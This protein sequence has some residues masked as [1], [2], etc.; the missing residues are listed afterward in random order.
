MVKKVVRRKKKTAQTA[1]EVAAQTSTQPASQITGQAAAGAGQIRRRERPSA[2]GALASNDRSSG[3]MPG[4]YTFKPDAGKPYRAFRL[5]F[6]ETS[7]VIRPWPNYD[8]EIYGN[9]NGRLDFGPFRTQPGKMGLI[10]ADWVRAIPAAKYFGEG[11][12]RTTCLLYNP[13]L[14]AAEYDRRTNPYIAIILAIK[15]AIKGGAP[16]YKAWKEM[17]LDRRGDQAAIIPSDSRL[18]FVQGAVCKDSK[19]IYLPG[20]TEKRLPYGMLPQD[21]TPVIQL[22]ASAV[23]GVIELAS[24]VNETWRGDPNDWENSMLYGDMVSPA[25][26]RFLTF[27]NPENETVGPLDDLSG[28]AFEAEAELKRVQQSQT[29][30][31]SSSGAKMEAQ[32]F[33]A[34]VD[35]CLVIGSQVFKNTLPKFE[36]EAADIIRQKII[37]WEDLLHIPTHDE[38][39][40]Y[41]ARACSP[42]GFM[43]QY[44]WDGLGYF[45]EEVRKICAASVQV[46]MDV[47]SSVVGSAQQPSH[48]SMSAAP[49]GLAGFDDTMLV[50]AGAAAGGAAV[51]DAEDEYE[52]VEVEVDDEEVE[53]VEEGVE[54]EVEVVAGEEGADDDEYEEVEV[55]EEGNEIVDG[56]EYEEV[57]VEE[58]EEEGDEVEEVEEVEATAPAPETVAPTPAPTPAPAKQATPPAS[59]PSSPADIARTAVENAKKR[60]AA[61]VAAADKAAGTPPAEPMQ[62]KAA[63]NGEAKKTVKKK[64]VKRKRPS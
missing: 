31:G 45:D 18:G 58:G 13:S 56:D 24:K 49:A 23:D 20:G 5:H 7:T 32:G 64:L 16:K 36:G 61:R 63:T 14:S 21:A 59:K 8:Y 40:L 55:D 39:R 22:N 48:T 35:N 50:G 37:W 34:R 30:G 9:E 6:R 57:E 54:V 62:Q 28:S 33:R 41:I 12:H 2:P 19:R 26:G 15:K 60:Q 27:W 17:F 43:L 46:S 42:Y 4:D 47:D 52:E 11:D 25:T 3:A 51:A 10:E 44:A 53:Y 1:A 38:L 29:H